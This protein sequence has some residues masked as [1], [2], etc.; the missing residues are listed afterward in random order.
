LALTISIEGV[1]QW[2]EFTCYRNAQPWRCDLP[3]FKQSISYDL[4]VK[5]VRRQVALSFDRDVPLNRA[6]Q[7]AQRALEIYA[8]SS[9]LLSQ[10]EIGGVKRPELVDLRNGSLPLS[11][12]STE[13]RV[14]HEGLGDSAWLPDVSLSIQFSAM[15]DGADNAQ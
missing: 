14:S 12:E 8:D 10:C 13:V 7:L 15:T 1:R 9:V 11:H 2:Y 6:R 4:T 3:E 5:G